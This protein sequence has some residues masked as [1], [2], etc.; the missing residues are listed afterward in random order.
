MSTP[1]LYSCHNFEPSTFHSRTELEEDLLK[2]M[3]ENTK[4]FVFLDEEDDTGGLKLEDVKVTTFPR[5]ELGE[6]QGDDDDYGASVE[7]SHFCFET[8]ALLV[9]SVNFNLLI[10]VAEMGGAYHFI[11]LQRL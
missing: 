10:C 3:E 11:L 6:D 7:K 9:S 1:L 8:N 2:A 4:V 5:R